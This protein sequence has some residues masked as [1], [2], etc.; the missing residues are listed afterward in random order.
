[1]RFTPAR[2]VTNIAV[3]SLLATAVAGCSS[4]PHPGM[5]HGYLIQPKTTEGPFCEH[6][7]YADL[8]GGEVQKVTELKASE[9]SPLAADDRP[10]D[11]GKLLVLNHPLDPLPPEIARIRRG[12]VKRFTGKFIRSGM[13]TWSGL[14]LE[15]LVA[16][17]VE[18]R[19]YDIRAHESRPIPD[20]VFTRTEQ[21]SFARKWTDGQRV[22]VEVIKVFPITLV[23]AEVFVCAANPLWANKKPL[24]ELEDDSGEMADGVT[25]VFLLDRREAQD[26]AYKYSKTVYLTQNLTNILGGIWEHAPRGPDW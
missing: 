8:K 12:I 3:I 13:M 22:E 18:R 16:V 6:H 17:S 15:R 9:P 11:A 25:D 19:V 26:V 20:P 4:P 5:E 14:D 24:P 1:M 21:L 10:Y 23:E 7:P 2:S